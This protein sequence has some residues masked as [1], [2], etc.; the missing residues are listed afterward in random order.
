MKIILSDGTELNNLER[1]GGGL[2]ATDEALT[3]ETLNGKLHGVKMIDT[4][5]D[6]S[7][8]ES[9]ILN[10]RMI[11]DVV[12]LGD[13]YSFALKEIDEKELELLRLQANIAYLSMMSDIELPA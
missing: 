1:I 3:N 2:F 5:E 12:K 6:G 11:G 4:L 7:T 9:D 8:F 10:M 13:R